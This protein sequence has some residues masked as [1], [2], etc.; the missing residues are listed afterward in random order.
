MLVAFSNMQLGYGQQFGTL[1][2]SSNFT[3]IWKFLRLSDPHFPL[4]CF[5]RADIPK[6]D[7]SADEGILVFDL[8]IAVIEKSLAR[9]AD[10]GRRRL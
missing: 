1:G 4:K 7:D 9:W 3:N 5:G 6:R 2:I 8:A 10:D